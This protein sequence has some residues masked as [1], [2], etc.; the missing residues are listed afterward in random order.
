MTSQSEVAEFCARLRERQH[1]LSKLISET[2]IGSGHASGLSSR[3]AAEVVALGEELQVADEELRVQCEELAAARLHVEILAARNEAL[4]GPDGTADLITDTHGIVVE[5]NRGALQ[6][7]GRSDQSG[8]RTSFATWF[9]A[10]DRRHIRSLISRATVA[11]ERM[12]AQVTLPGIGPAGEEP[13]RVTVERRVEPHTGTALLCWELTAVA[14]PT[15][16]AGDGLGHLRLVPGDRALTINDR[17]DVIR[18]V[19]STARADLAAQLSAEVTPDGLLPR[20]LELAVRWVPGAEKASICRSSGQLSPST[21]C[22]TPAAVAAFD[23]VEAELRQGPTIDVLGGAT[24]IRVD[25]LATDA[26]WPDLSQHA[27]RLDVRSVLV[28]PLPVLRR[29]VGTISLYASRPA[30]FTHVS[31]IVL[32]VFA[33]R[34]SIALAYIDQVSNLHR[35]IGSRQ[36]IGQ[37]VGI[38]MERHKLTPEQAFERL[39]EASQ[40]SHIKL[41]NL[42]A[43]ICQT[44]QEPQDIHS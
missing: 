22:A 13:F 29:G 19:L 11:G 8:G 35:A 36:E 43:H 12:S 32:P 42:A 15:E 23:R 44:G 5:A 34:A 10:P 30:A 20:V 21:V 26:R 33:S 25:D 9:A 39:V 37:A 14:R 18:R 41:R 2:D 38:L 31:E 27:A 7:F 4:A 1:Q 3:L 40:H 17:D 28:C 6:L 24:A 16:K